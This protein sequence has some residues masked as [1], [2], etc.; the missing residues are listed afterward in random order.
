MRSRCRRSIIAASTPSSAASK[1]S[2][3]MQP[4]SVPS[5]GNNEAGPHTRIS[6]QPSAR[7]ACRSERAT[8]ECFTSPTMTTLSF[9]KS[10]PLAWRKVSMSSRPWVGWLLRPS[11]ALSNTV[12]GCA[13]SASSATAPSR[14][15]RT[16]KAC[17]PIASSVFRV[18]RS[19][20]PLVVDAVEASKFSR[21][22]PSRCAASEKLERVR[23]DGSK[24]SVHTALPAST[25]RSAVPP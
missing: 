2:V 19:A 15:W 16:T 18:S 4:S 22:A 7:N 20:S 10:S 3:T 8:R 21:S 1:S 5:S 14:L 12:P 25:S 13:A 17:T 24:N 9:E 6:P 11:P 23:V